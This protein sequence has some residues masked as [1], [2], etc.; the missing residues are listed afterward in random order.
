MERVIG[1]VRQKPADRSG[2]PGVHWLFGFL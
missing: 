1:M 2:H